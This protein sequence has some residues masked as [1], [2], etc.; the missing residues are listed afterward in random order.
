MNCFAIA[1]SLGLQHGVPLEK[2]VE[3]FVFR[4]FEPM[5]A[6]TGND[7]IKFAS[8]IIDYIFRELA[9]SY[10]GR[11][12]LAQVPPMALATDPAEESQDPQGAED[13]LQLQLAEARHLPESD[14]KLYENDPCQEC[15]QLMMVRSGTCLKCMNC[16][17]TWGCS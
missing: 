3:T 5:G 2:F 16:G 17:A 9:V 10:L 8:S 1:I 12:D 13:P 7:R 14:Q 11:D 4:K 15:G 6:V